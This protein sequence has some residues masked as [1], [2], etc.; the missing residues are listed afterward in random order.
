MATLNKALTRPA[1]I[2]GI[3]IVPLTIVCGAITLLAVYTTYWLLFLL[4]PAIIEMKNKSRN[5]IHFFSLKLLELK[6]RGRKASSKFYGANVI[7]SNQY[8]DVDVREFNEKMRLNESVNI[9][10]YIP[11]SSHIHERVIKNRRGD[12]VSTWE[13]GGTIFECED[14]G[15]LTHMTMQL[16]NLIRTYEGLPFTFY[17]HRVREKYSDT[18]ESNSGI[19]F[20]D[21]VSQMYYETVK[22]KP[23]RR[24]RLFF[25]ACY[26]PLNRIEKAAM[27]GKSLGVK[28]RLLNASLKMMLEHWETINTSLARYSATP[29][30]IYTK[31]NRVYSSQLEFYNRLLTGKWQR[32]A[33]TRSP[34]YDVLGSSDL[35][36][37]TDTGQSSHFDDH[38]FFRSLEVKDY[39]PETF[40]GLY[41]ALLYADCDYVL[42]QS[43]SAMAKDEAKDHINLSLKRLQ[44]AGDDAISQQEDLIVALDLLQSGVISFGKYHFSLI[45]TSPDEQQVIRDTNGLA[46]PMKDLG[47]IVTLSTMSL[48]AAYLS[49][50]PGVYDLRPRLVPV[51]SINFADMASFHN[52]HPHKRDGNPWGEAIASLKTP[53][54]GNY[55]LNLHN[56]QA[57]VNE[58]NEKTPGNTMIIGSTGTG[59]STLLAAIKHLAQKYRREASFSPE[60]THKRLTTVYFDKDRSAE[61]SIRQMG[62]R[63][64]RIRSGESTGWNPFSL[65]PTK[66][67]LNFIKQLIR[68]LC[69]RDGKPLDPRDEERI[70]Q[71][72]NTIMLDYPPEYRHYGITRLLEVL[73]EPPTKEARTNGLRIRLKQWA[74]GGE[75][76]WV[77]DNDV[78]T[79]NIDECDNFGIDGTEFLDDKDVCA[80]I[81]FYLLY[82]VTSLLDGRRLIMFMDEFW[83]WLA[84][85]EFSKFALNMLKVIRKLNGIFIPATQ[86]PEEMAKSEISAAIIEQCG[87]QI[88]MANPKATREDYVDKLKVPDSVFN[89]VKELD[90]G[91]RQMV[92]LKTP[93]RRGENRPFISLAT[94]DLSGLGK[95]TKILS[96][97]EDN[98]KIFDA[99]WNENMNPEDWKQEFLQK[100]I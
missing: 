43:F 39:A 40:T 10:K 84:D 93:L 68:M 51:S 88:F 29:L 58:F 44:S 4:I 18:F 42:T 7:S 65:S 56:S 46:E 5:D 90:P 99:I 47:I 1:N 8:D 20:S 48:P 36:F 17:I 34:F 97:S 91:A 85:K 26:I 73:P 6:T 59:K 3:P 12:L 76:G 75:F 50:L 13:V 81:T 83:K 86:S 72:V 78:D 60:A 66:R 77:F 64:F 38:Q 55:W 16:N 67:N 41:D 32:V 49:Q 21:E 23:F 30:Q 54:G 52:F 31:D 15:H 22:K 35:F 89:I 33:V 100:C 87:T 98:L 63:Y 80:P 28:E 74:K 14:E 70:S 45:V 37:S 94:L 11:Y 24:C 57:G 61:L 71:G 92:I 96:A 9:S 79:F 27:K 2:K 69:T 19:E 95:Y 82:R 53:S 62:G 25:T